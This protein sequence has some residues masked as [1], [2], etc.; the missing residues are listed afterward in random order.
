MELMNYET[1]AQ[2]DERAWNNYIRQQEYTDGNIYSSDPATKTK[3]IKTAVDS[4]LA[5]FE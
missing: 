1:P 4:V 5:E 2:Q 3:A